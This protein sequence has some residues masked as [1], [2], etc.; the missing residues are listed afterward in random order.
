[1]EVHIAPALATKL[2]T[3]RAKADEQTAVLQLSLQQDVDGP[4]A[5]DIENSK[6]VV[7]ELDVHLKRGQGANKTRNGRTGGG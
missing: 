5:Q 1:M 4:V 3:S 6:L 7:K 2:I